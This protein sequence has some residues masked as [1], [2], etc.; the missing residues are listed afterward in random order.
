VK[1]TAH[2]FEVSWEVCNKVGGIY[3]VLTSKMPWTQKEFPTYV[4]VGPYFSNGTP[5]PEF[6]E[7]ELPLEF[8]GV[9]TVAE[10]KGVTFH[11][12]TWNV[13]GKPKA[14]LVSWDGLIPHLDKYK[15]KLWESYKID[16]LGTDFYDVDQ[17]LLWSIAVGIVVEAYTANHSAPVVLHA[18][19]WMSG[20]AVLYAN[21]STMPLLHTV[22]TT[23]ATVLGRSLSS[24]GVNIA[25]NPNGF[26]ADDEARMAGVLA[27]HQIEALSAKTAAVFTTVSKVTAEEATAFLG[28]TPDVVTEN[29]LNLEEFLPFDA[30]CVQRFAIRRRLEEF[31]A[32]YFFPYYA[33]NLGQVHYQ[34]TMGRY[35]LHNKGYDTYLQTLG[36]LNAELQES[37]ST[38]TVISF[39]LVPAGSGRPRPDVLHN[40]QSFRYGHARYVQ[41]CAA[42]EFDPAM[43]PATL[44]LPTMDGTPPLSAF[45]MLDE[46]N[47]PII[48]SAR[49]AGLHNASEDRVKVIF[50][51]VYLDG[52]DGL[53][54]IPLYQLISA[55]DLGIFPSY[56]EPWGYTPMESLAA[57]VPAITSN[58][59]GFGRALESVKYPENTGFF[60]IDR[61]HPEHD[62]AT[63]LLEKLRIALFEDSR[64]S[65]GRR[66]EAYATSTLFSWERLYVNYRLA[67]QKATA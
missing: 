44:M 29:G 9:A 50:L 62:A 14:L 17:P 65:L 38:K 35:E 34:F 64:T 57:G 23:H 2:L 45:E 12:G 52:F 59:A 60:L 48:L 13:T 66:I 30:L 27:K 51:P 49:T 3:T 18:H 41:E 61:S 33:V 26:N 5:P 11:Y 39:I 56:Y 20:G 36:T 40:L 21:L 25:S 16:T 8:K 42:R 54:D 53:L 37:H 63:Q 43:G 10:K 55:F 19:E 31:V 7:E 58:L 22:F 24:K 6:Q 47:D 4:A 67:Y 15:A 46:D 32:A 1:Q 28:R